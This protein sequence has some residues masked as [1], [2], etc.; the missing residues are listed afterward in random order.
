[1]ASVGR[2]KGAKMVKLRKSYRIYT[3]NLGNL[4]INFCK[5]RF[6]LV[7]EIE[8]RLKPHYTESRTNGYAYPKI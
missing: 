7:R 4:S 8:L 2:R 1:M 5:T 3:M 6:F